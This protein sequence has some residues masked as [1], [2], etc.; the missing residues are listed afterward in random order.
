MPWTPDDALRHDKKAK[1]P[2]EQR[3]WA[4]VANN[5][6]K[7]TGDDARAV[8]GANAA[9]LKGKINRRGGARGR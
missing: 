8:R 4:D 6:R 7:R 1:S 9:V 2:K 5:I 3:Q